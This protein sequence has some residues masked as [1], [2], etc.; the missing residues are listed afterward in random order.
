MR[1]AGFVDKL[2]LNKHREYIVQEYVVKKRPAYRIAGELGVHSADITRWLQANGYEVRRHRE[3]KKV[4]SEQY[5]LEM[6]PRIDR[7]R[8]LREAGCPIAAIAA[9]TG[10]STGTVS[11][12]LEQEGL[13]VRYRPRG[14]AARSRKIDDEKKEEIRKQI[15]AA[16][17]D[18]KARIGTLRSDWSDGLTP[19][20]MDI[21]KLWIAT[22]L[23]RGQISSQLKC[24]RGTVSKTLKLVGL[25]P[26]TRRIGRPP[27]S[28]K[29]VRSPAYIGFP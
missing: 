14:T 10:V 24:S 4:S 15:E 20:Q 21:V 9:E 18:R 16:H 17:E 19:L 28:V 23:S 3:A 8:E 6:K 25:V 22:E 26:D 27:G 11:R 12:V 7:I 2:G 1:D 29:G 5:R 13:S